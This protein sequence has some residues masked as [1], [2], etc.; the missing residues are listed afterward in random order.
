MGGASSRITS[1]IP[2]PHEHGASSRITSPIPDPYEH[3]IEY[4]AEDGSE[5]F[6][7]GPINPWKVLGLKPGASRDVVK[8]AFV[9]KIK[10]SARQK[11]AMVSLANHMLTSSAQSRYQQMPG[12]NKFFIKDCDVFVLAA[13][14]HTAAIA[15]KTAN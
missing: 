11:R 13:C 3:I 7:N 1:P 4:V 12:T 9:E 10:Q 6:I 8:M 15:S 14:G 2:D 5:V